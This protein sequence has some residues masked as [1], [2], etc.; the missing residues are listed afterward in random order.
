MTSFILHALTNVLY[1]STYGIYYGGRYLLYGQEKTKEQEMNE[2]L[3]EK[4][5]ILIEKIEK[6]EKEKET[7]ISHHNLQI[8]SQILDQ[9]C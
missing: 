2:I 7:N 5:D 3:T 8:S 4:M 6:L 9:P 1:Y